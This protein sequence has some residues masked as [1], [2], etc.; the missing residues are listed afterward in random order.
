MSEEGTLRGVFSTQFWAQE[1]LR[2]SVLAEQILDILREI[3]RRDKCN[4]KPQ[5]IAPGNSRQQASA[6]RHLQS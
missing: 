4:S 5:L 1:E 3:K 6:V 2:F